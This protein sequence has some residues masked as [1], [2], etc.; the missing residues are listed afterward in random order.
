ME[1]DDRADLER[2]FAAI[3]VL[4]PASFSCGGKEIESPLEE[5][6]YSNCLP[7]VLAN[8][9]RK[10]PNYRKAILPKNSE[11]PMRDERRGNRVG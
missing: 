7:S 4:S 1:P 9:P 5:F 10:R 2:V 3:S 11:P 6:L 8:R